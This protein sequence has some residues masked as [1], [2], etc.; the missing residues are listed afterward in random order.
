M[1][2]PQIVEVKQMHA[3]DNQ[4]KVIAKHPTSSAKCQ[5][6]N[7]LRKSQKSDKYGKCTACKLGCTFSILSHSGGKPRKCTHYGKKIAH[8]EFLRY[9]LIQACEKLFECQKCKRFELERQC[10]NYTAEHTGERKFKCEQ[11]GKSFAK[12]GDFGKAYGRPSQ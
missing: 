3:V 11:Y 9:M 1:T 2:I 8:G 12:K 4:C 7:I 10:V 6:N 5:Q